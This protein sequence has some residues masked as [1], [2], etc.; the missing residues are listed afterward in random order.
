MGVEPCGATL[1]T[2][3]SI[4]RSVAFVDDHESVTDCPEL[5]VSGDALMV[6]V[7]CGVGAGAGAGGVAAT[8]F[9]NPLRT[10][11][12]IQPRKAEEYCADC[13]PSFNSLLRRLRARA[14][15]PTP[16]RWN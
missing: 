6:T 16:K 11:R 9:C 15:R 4:E 5:T 7:G 1:P 13:G 8:C 2:P 3:G 12:Q 10:L 14:L